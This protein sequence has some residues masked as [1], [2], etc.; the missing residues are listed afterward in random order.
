MCCAG[1]LQKQDW[2]TPL[3]H[4]VIQACWPAGL[5]GAVLRCWIRNNMY[6]IF[7]I[8]T[9]I[10]FF[11]TWPNVRVL[12]QAWKVL[13]SE[14]HLFPDL[15]KAARKYFFGERSDI[16]FAKYCRVNIARLC[17]RNVL[18]ALTQPRNGYRISGFLFHNAVYDLKNSNTQIK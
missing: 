12:A 7:L 11:C 15:D 6:E 9:S 13:K 4:S 10:W 1:W 2:E 17:F 16:S 5:F 8:N 14:E 3:H 18:L